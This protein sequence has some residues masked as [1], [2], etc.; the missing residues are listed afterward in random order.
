MSSPASPDRF[1]PTSLSAVY[2]YGRSSQQSRPSPGFSMTLRDDLMYIRGKNQTSDETHVKEDE[3]WTNQHLAKALCL[4]RV[5]VLYFGGKLANYESP[6]DIAGPLLSSVPPEKIQKV[7]ASASTNTPVVNFHQPPCLTACNI[8]HAPGLR[9]DFYCNL[10]TWSKALERIAVGLGPHVYWWGV[11]EHVEVINL[12][13]NYMPITSLESDEGYLYVGTL[14]GSIFSVCEKSNKVVAFFEL[15]TGSILCMLKHDDKLFAGDEKGNVL[16]FK[17]ELGQLQRQ[18]SQ[19]C[20]NQQICGLAANELGLLAVGANDNNC[21]LWEISVG[22]KLK[23]KTVLPHNAAVKA[24][25]FC[26]WCKSLLATG[27][28]SKDRKIRFWHIFTGTL[29]AEFNTQSQVTSLSWCISKRE[30]MATFGFGLST[31]ALLA[32]YLYPL[33]TMVKTVPRS[34]N[35][36][37]L[38]SV[39]DPSCTFVCVVATDFTVRVYHL[40]TKGRQ[41]AADA[42]GISSFGSTIIAL[43]EG[44]TPRT[45]SIR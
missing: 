2:K 31:S 26:P 1:I 38:S 30:I 6:L 42:M 12:G 14:N 43:L 36:R 39:M 32:V 25:A 18:Y 28:G 27:G 19:K 34:P 22:P 4:G 8:L 33:F 29:L 13:S 16:I 44:V 21:S 7:L 17:I 37:V 9:N 24:I 23:P 15:D 5:K 11:N 10:A 40:W 20:S 3:E 35:L 45:S 41:L